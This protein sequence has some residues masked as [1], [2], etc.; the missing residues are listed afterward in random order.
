MIPAG[1]HWL[2]G[3]LGLGEGVTSGSGPGA[4]GEP[5]NGMVGFLGPTRGGGAFPF[6]STFAGSCGTSG[7]LASTSGGSS[8][9]P[10]G[11]S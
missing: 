9:S 11:S 4:N 1:G 3:G 5:G 6:S 7:A 8:V 2:N 10:M